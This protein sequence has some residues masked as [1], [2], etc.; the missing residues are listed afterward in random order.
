[1]GG[2]KIFY[3][4]MCGTKTLQLCRSSRRPLSSQM[5]VE[6]NQKAV[7]I[8]VPNQWYQLHNSNLTFI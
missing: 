7:M 1:M 2:T 4:T 8:M 3:G 6:K 5:D